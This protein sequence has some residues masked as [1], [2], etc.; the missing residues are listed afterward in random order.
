[1]TSS[2][3]SFYA[4]DTVEWDF[5]ALNLSTDNEYLEGVTLD[6][7]S[8]FIVDSVSEFFDQ[9]EDTLLL[10]SGE[11]GDGG[12]FYWYGHGTDNWGS[13]SVPAVLSA[14]FFPLVV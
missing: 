8:G 13:G 9:T 1:M 11:P 14:Q 12:S 4:G 5:T 7:P 2:G 10:L 3:E 6:F